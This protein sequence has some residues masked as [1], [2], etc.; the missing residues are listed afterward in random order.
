MFQL[1]PSL[2]EVMT[3]KAWNEHYLGLVVDSP[4]MFLGLPFYNLLN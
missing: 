1:L 3:I 2:M 4:V